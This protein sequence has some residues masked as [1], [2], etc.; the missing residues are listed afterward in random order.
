MV[1]ERVKK[2]TT[3]GVTVSSGSLTKTID[4]PDLTGK[5]L[6]EAEKL[7]EQH[8]LKLGNITFQINA[9]LLPNT[10]VEQLPSAGVAVDSG[11]TIDLFVVKA[12]KL[13]DE[14]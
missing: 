1:T 4:V 11:K 3:V 2:G 5:S 13:I 7:I 9:E 12:G 10:V 14:R 8:G 6:L